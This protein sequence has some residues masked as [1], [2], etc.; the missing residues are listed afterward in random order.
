MEGVVM[1]DVN[2]WRALFREALYKKRVY[3]LDIKIPELK[4]KFSE[5]RTAYSALYALLLEKNFVMID[6]YKEDVRFVTLAVPENT[7]L[8][9][10]RRRESFSI[11]LSKYDS[12]LEY[13]TSYYNFALEMLRSDKIKIL[14]AIIWF[15]RWNNLSHAS[16]SPNTQAMSEVMTEVRNKTSNTF[17]VQNIQA[18]IDSLY[19]IASDIDNILGDLDTYHAESYKGSVR[20]FIAA[21]MSGVVTLDAIKVHFPLAFQ[22]WP[23]HT[24][25]VKELIHEDYSPDAQAARQSVLQKLATEDEE[26]EAG[27]PETHDSRLLLMDGLHALGSVSAV[28]YTIIDKIESNHEL[29]RNKKKSFIEIIKDIIAVLFNMRRAADLYVCA[30]QDAGDSKIEVIDHQL[31]ITELTD[32]AKALRLF[33]FSGTN[34]AILEGRDDAELLESL[35]QN[36]YDIRRYVRLL[37]ALDEFFKTD[38]K[39]QNKRQIKGIKPEISMIKHALSNAITKKEYYL[40]GQKVE[41]Q[42]SA[43]TERQ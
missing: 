10:T 12:L 23:F 6:P 4:A 9:E 36:V 17:S 25:L 2:E 22:G 21:N 26:P 31:F 16:S 13:M 27:G 40:V 37:V 5:F 19:V 33:A 42:V 1:A 43:G 24:A 20:A 34:D 14:R 38:A 18:C 3:L 11:R 7:P 29:Y 35:Y 30:V 41:E 32:K 8:A 28:F 39:I 15:V